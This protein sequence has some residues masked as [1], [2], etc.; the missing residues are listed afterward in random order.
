MADSSWQPYD[1]HSQT[2]PEATP[3]GVEEPTPEA[4]AG[5]PVEA[6]LRLPRIVR[7]AEETADD[8]AYYVVNCPS[9]AVAQAIANRLPTRRTLLVRNLGAVPVYVNKSRE[10]QASDAGGWRI[11]AGGQLKLEAKCEWFAITEDGAVASL[12]VLQEFTRESPLDQ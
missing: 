9:P 12:A 1:P 11:D 4:P 10:V 8:A 3:A 7:V 6:M 2:T 5:R